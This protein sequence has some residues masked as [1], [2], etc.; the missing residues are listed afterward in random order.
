[1][2]SSYIG[3]TH[4]FPTIEQVFDGFIK[5]W[6]GTDGVE[7]L[8]YQV[9]NSGL[10][11]FKAALYSIVISCC[12]SYASVFPIIKP[13]A[14]LISNFRFLPLAG[15]SLYLSFLIHDARLVQV[16][17]LTIFMTLFL[18][19]SILGQLQGIEE[20][21]DHAKTIKCTKLQI[22]TEVIIKGKIDYVIESIRQNLA[23]IC[24]F[25]VIIEMINTASGGLGYLIGNAQKNGNQGQVVALQIIILL[26]GQL[27]DWLITTFRKVTFKFSNF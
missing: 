24:G 7:P 11:F 26:F 8:V 22:L 15:V 27:I 5:L 9:L 13:M 20:E 19:T 18:V 21:I 17:V 2:L 12:I 6:K 4:L 10:L 16:S 25:L 23:I 3:T 14:K 1:M